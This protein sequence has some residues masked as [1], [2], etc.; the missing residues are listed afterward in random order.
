[1]KKFEICFL[2]T[3]FSFLFFSNLYGN[4]IDKEKAL[5]K[6]SAFMKSKGMSKELKLVTPDNTSHKLYGVGTTPNEAFYVFNCDKGGFVIVSGSD[7]TEDILGYSD[8][9][10]FS[11]ENMPENLK[12][13]FDGYAEEI[14][15]VE[16]RT[17]YHTLPSNKAQEPPKL[18]KKAIT[19]LLTSKWDQWDPYNLKCP[20]IEGSHAPTGCGATAIAQILY[21]HKWPQGYTEKFDDLPS[22]KFDWDNMKKSYSGNETT[23]QKNAVAN[24][25]LYC[26]HACNTYY[27]SWSSS[28]SSLYYPE[29]FTR[30]GYPQ[31]P[32]W[33]NRST[34]PLDKWEDLIYNELANGRPV[35]YTGSHGSEYECA[36]HAFVCDGY[37]GNGMF[38]INWGWSGS[39]NGYFRLQALNPYNN[40]GDGV[41]AGYTQDQEIFIGISPTPINEEEEE[42]ED[43]YSCLE[44]D[45]LYLAEDYDGIP[46]M[47]CDYNKSKGL[48]DFRVCYRY[49][50]SYYN[51]YFYAGKYDAGLGL[52]KNGK[53]I[54]AKSVCEP[55]E[56]VWQYSWW[57]LDGLG[58][59]LSD[60]TYELKGVGRKH[61][62]TKWA[63][64]IYADNHYVSFVIKKGKVTGTNMGREATQYRT[65]NVEQVF[66]DKNNDP[67]VKILRATF[68]NYNNVDISPYLFLYVD[69]QHMNCEQAYIPQG[70][71]DYID[72][73]FKSNNGYHQ[74][75]ITSEEYDSTGNNTLYLN[76]QFYL[77]DHPDG[78]IDPSKSGV[79]RV[80]PPVLDFES[81][82][83]GQSKTKG[84]MVTNVGDV[85]I[86][87]H[88]SES[89]L[90]HVTETNKSFTLAPT[91]SRR[92]EV[93]FSP[94]SG[95]ESVEDALNIYSNAINGTQFVQLKGTGCNYNPPEA[96]DLGLPSGTKWASY[97]VGA[98]RPEE[99]GD[100]YAWGETEPKDNYENTNYSFWDSSNETYQDL[101]ESICGTK[102]DVAHV[103]WGGK[104]EMPSGEQIDELINNCTYEETQINGV[105][106]YK[107]TSKIN[108]GNIFLPFAG[109][110]HG[111][112]LLNNGSKGLYLSG[113]YEDD[114]ILILNFEYGSANKTRYWSGIRSYG[115]TVRPVI[116]TNETAPYAVLQDGKLTF[117]YNNKRTSWESK[118]QTSTGPFVY[119][120]NEDVNM[121]D[122]NGKASTVTKAAFD[123]SF[124]DF[125][126]SSTF[127]WFYKMS[128]LTDIEGME[129]LNTSAT[130]TLR[131]MFSGCSKL[132]TID[133]SHLDTRQNTSTQNMFRDCSNLTSID[134]SHFNT[135]NV[136]NMNYMFYNCK[137]LQ[138]IDLSGITIGNSTSTSSMFANATALQKI[139][140]SKDMEKLDGNAFTKV[141]TENS[142]CIIYAPNDFNFGLDTNRSCFKWKNGWFC[143]SGYSKIDEINN[144]ETAS[145]PIFNLHGIKVAESGDNISSLQPG[146]YVTNG[147]KIVVR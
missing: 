107:F 106:G 66:D 130:T 145:Y 27:R 125:S 97:N 18:S 109:Y 122:W 81:V 132:K 6:A 56:S 147:M 78:N 112:N 33:R 36:G 38:H 55:M 26:G 144:H 128:K 113:T 90:F 105:N 103:K 52:F 67:T 117:Y 14:Q 114:A 5:Q 16:S 87:F 58:K 83:Y 124:A 139:T 93:T 118:S 30:L 65:I 32:Q 64:N 71:T 70:G 25:M 116:N 138:S 101:G 79:I 89:S 29:A 13:W 98:N 142:P 143:S 96:I 1:M 60:G 146:I 72:F 94:S 35:L 91:E 9:G 99:Y 108:G 42:F 84:F 45:W 100:Y 127:A 3:V 24:L 11:L 61:G 40:V 46:T 8:S 53:L 80:A 57:Y 4:P 111:Y 135:S 92:F 20:V 77:G 82:V 129:Y 69:G 123:A 68:R 23:K 28:S 120:L 76:H 39:G 19:P 131:G 121:P 134:L 62:T 137:A 110:R 63:P 104:W 73:V 7:N 37:D 74:I 47:T 126:P 43:I 54:D 34:Y 59:N 86:T 50:F 17:T 140:V 15:W 133:L 141:G 44:V 51:N 115:V 49:G 136:E 2:L 22:I 10:V 31:E 85:D 48:A 95:M 88:V 119:D 21:Y 12:S 102:Y 75:L 41:L